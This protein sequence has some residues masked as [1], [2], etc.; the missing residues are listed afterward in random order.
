MAAPALVV[1]QQGITVLSA[2]QLNSYELTCDTFAQLRAFPGTAGMQVYARGQTAVSDGYQG[3]FYWNATISNPVDDNV[4]TIVPSGSTQGAWIRLAFAQ[5]AGTG[6]SF[7]TGLGLTSWTAPTQTVAATVF[8][9]T[10]VGG[11]GGGGGAGASANYVGGPGGG[12]ATVIAWLTGL[13]AGTAYSIAIGA[14]GAGGPASATAGTSGGNTYITALGTTYTAGGGVGGA[15][16][17]STTT[18]QTAGGAPTNGSILIAGG[19]GFTFGNGSLTQ[20][21]NSNFG[22]GAIAN[23]VAGTAAAGVNATGYGAGGTGGFAGG[24][25]T[26]EPGGN[27]TQ[28]FILI[29]WGI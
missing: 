26:A 24:A 5:G 27:G 3:E 18:K 9:A 29:E 17:S 10:L 21:G 25:G 28:G 4:S 2:D 11:G 7:L 16:G 12:A 6:Y 13:T 20:G 23:Q 15:A 1:N 14:A 22:A 8:K 19:D